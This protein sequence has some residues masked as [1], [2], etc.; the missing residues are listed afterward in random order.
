VDRRA[1]LADAAL[2]GAS[3]LFA[4]MIVAFAAIPLYREWGRLAAGPYAVGA[5]AAVVIA[6]RGASVRAR[7]VVAVAVFVGAALLPLGLEVAWR[8]GTAPG[9]HA[10][11]EA[12]VVEEAAN[13]LL[14]GRDPYAASYASGPLT[15]RPEGTKTHFPYLPAMLVFG[16]P[17]A[18][19]GDHPW[20]D[21]RL[22]F[23]AAALG[24]AGLALRRWKAGARTKLRAFQFLAVLPTGALLM[25]TGGDDL[26]VLA[27]LLLTLVLAA[28]GSLLPAGIA[29]GLAMATKQTAWVLVPFIGT[30]IILC[31][32]WQARRLAGAVAAVTLPVIVA[33]VAWNPSAFW[34]DV[35]RF[36]LGLGEAATAAATPTLGSLLIDAFP[37]MRGL[38]TG[39]LIGVVA[40]TAIALLIRW[41][42]FTAGG[43]AMRTA[44]IASLAIATAPAARAGYVVYPVDL[45]VWGWLLAGSALAAVDRRAG[46]SDLRPST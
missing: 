34:E 28:D 5:L 23:S 40:L 30:A 35:V 15:A 41:P 42:P 20:T 2:Y 33:F 37:D 10:Q 26:P 24:L 38:L 16:L 32:G 21:A 18:A 11:S 7:A 27:L 36:P 4:G 3:V 13:A 12:I 43:A 44:A 19:G 29:L 46:A 1:A 25:A 17:R 14:D 45:A 9:L 6:Y 39:V 31:F 22:A 8:A